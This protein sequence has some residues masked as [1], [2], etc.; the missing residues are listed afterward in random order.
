MMASD[1]VTASISN[2]AVLMLF[3]MWPPATAATPTTTPAPATSRMAVGRLVVV[4][5]RGLMGR[6]PTS[7]FG[8]ISS[9][10]QQKWPTGCQPTPQPA[11]ASRCELPSVKGKRHFDVW[12]GDTRVWAGGTCTRVGRSPDV[13]HVWEGDTRLVTWAEQRAFGRRQ[14]T[15]VPHRV[16]IAWGRGGATCDTRNRVC[17]LQLTASTVKPYCIYLYATQV[18]A[19]CALATTDYG[20]TP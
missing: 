17:R 14:G 7:E 9:F 12:E 10:P 20:G 19:P 11:E 15:S 6:L 16:G 5:K 2:T 3:M 4:R 13:G 1:S 8:T 18:Y